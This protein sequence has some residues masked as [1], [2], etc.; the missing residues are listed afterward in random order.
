M[1]ENIGFNVKVGM[2][3]AEI[4]SELQKAE[5]LLRQFQ[6]QLRK[7][8]NTIEINMLNKEI[9]ALNPQID[10]YRT[11]LQ[12]VG[13]PAGDAT[14]SLINFSRIAQD[15]P[16][17]MM[18]IANNLNPMVE[19]FQ[20]LAAT[21]G[22][23][24]KALAAMAQGLVGPAGIGVAIGLLSALLSTYSK[25]IGNFFKGATGEL[26]DFI[27]KINTLNDEL[28]KIAGKTEAKQI[29]GEVYIGIIGSKADLQQRE[30]ALEE[31]KKLSI[32]F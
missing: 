31:L 24:K 25:E 5:N 18:G 26:D 7:S 12:K 6:G 20:R 9:A 11:A 21:E 32:A 22:G 30:T 1:A 13:K 4:Q 10:A 2:D 15:A 28:F 23:T 3:V 17:G 8:T 19:S 29:K 16:F 14:Q 27:K